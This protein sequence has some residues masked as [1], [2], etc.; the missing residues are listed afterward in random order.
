MYTPRSRRSKSEK[1][2]KHFLDN[3]INELPND[4]EYSCDFGHKF[5]S[6]YI[7]GTM[8]GLKKKL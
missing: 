8:S 4:K 6:D 5:I 2:S 3:V 7:K 1:I